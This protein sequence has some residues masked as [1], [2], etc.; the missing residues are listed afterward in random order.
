MI[1]EFDLHKPFDKDVSS[2][3]E[4]TYSGRN[5]SRDAKRTKEMFEILERIS[6]G[7]N[8]SREAKNSGPSVD[9]FI[10][11]IH[12]LN[13]DMISERTKKTLRDLRSRRE[14]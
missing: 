10:N 2:L 12:E 6:A 8:M 4:E 14:K 5:V 7:S 9:A 13:T 3:F 1:G 11:R